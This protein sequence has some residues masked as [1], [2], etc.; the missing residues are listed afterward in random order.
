MMFAGHALLAFALAAGAAS[1]AGCDADRALA[2]GVLAG[3]FGLVPDVD[4]LY[5]PVGLAGAASLPAAETAFWATGNVVHRTATHSLVVGGAAAVAAGLWA[6]RTRPGRALAALLSAAVVAVGLADAALVAIVLAAFV[7]AVVA[8]AEAAARRG[9]AARDV[10]LAAAVGLLSHPFGDVFTGGPPALFYPMDVAVLAERVVLHPDP[11]LNLLGA[12]G[13]E[14][15]TAWAAVVVYLRV[16]DR[17][18]TPYVGPHAALGVGFAGAVL[19]LP[20]PSLEA[21]YRFVAGAL[22][23]GAIAAA[24][25]RVGDRRTPFRP[26]DDR[27]LYRLDAAVTGL[28]ALSAALV[29]YGILYVWL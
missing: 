23:V 17:R 10:A 15:A 14:V 5:A 1:L 13:L 29:A 27:P 11:T 20:P 6:R 3:V 16:T 7:A 21:P 12:F 28:V 26:T 2:V 25:V 8:V 18:L 9:I 4:I 22:G 19:L 24:G